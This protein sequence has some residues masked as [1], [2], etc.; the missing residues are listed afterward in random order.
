MKF[1]GILLALSLGF[2]ISAAHGQQARAPVTPG[3][4]V[5]GKL[6]YVA[7]MPGELDQWVIQ[8]LR[9]WGKYD[10]SGNSEGV[11]LVLRA[12]TPPKRLQI[13]QSE[14][15]PIRRPAA[16]PSILSLDLVDWVT[17]QRLW[18]CKIS[19]RKQKKDTNTS[20]GPDAVLDARG[21]KPD[22]IAE[23]CVRW[24]G[25]YVTQLEQGHTSK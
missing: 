15:P 1:N 20:V 4:L 3:R 18:Q 14:H 17:G 24:L 16:K 25:E 11:D 8:D 5:S 6:I 22:Q 13:Y 10:V 12:Q 21:M 9:A 2:A 7:P 23:R 19:D